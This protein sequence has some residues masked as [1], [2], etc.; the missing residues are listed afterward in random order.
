MRSINERA[1]V[2]N[3]EDGFSFKISTMFAR[4]TPS[5]MM[6]MRELSP[7][8]NLVTHYSTNEITG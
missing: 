7:S 5:D 4:E 1:L 2:F 8:E 3:L 6:I